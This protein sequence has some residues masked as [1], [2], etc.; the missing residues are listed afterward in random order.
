MDQTYGQSK[1]DITDAISRPILRDEYSIPTPL[2]NLIAEYVTAKQRP[3][4][5]GQTEY[6]MTDLEFWNKLNQ[7]SIE[8]SSQMLLLGLPA[9]GNNTR[10]GI[11]LRLLDVTFPFEL[12]V[13]Q[14]QTS[15]GKQETQFVLTSSN[16]D[17]DSI[18]V[19]QCLESR[20][21]VLLAHRFRSRFH[22]LRFGSE[23]NF[24]SDCDQIRKACTSL[25]KHTNSRKYESYSEIH[26][27]LPVK[28]H[29]QT[30]FDAFQTLCSSTGSVNINL[31]G[32]HIEPSG[33]KWSLIAR[34]DQIV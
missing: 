8:E 20:C 15:Q 22:G 25:L 5:K 17:V 33:N 34:I 23:N 31:S 29:K 18:E 27:R 16:I 26:I 11:P 9:N 19:I 2:I 13:V 1:Y 3:V 24:Q 6:P 32:I 7:L 28:I 4:L 30:D 12:E 21:A 10:I 14:K